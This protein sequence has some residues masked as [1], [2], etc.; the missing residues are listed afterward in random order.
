MAVGV[1]G[2][3]GRSVRRAVTI[4]GIAMVPA[5]CFRTVLEHRFLFR[6]AHPSWRYF[7]PNAFDDV[8]LALCLVL[9]VAV[10][11][12]LFRFG[13]GRS[14][15]WWL[16][17]GLLVVAAAAASLIIDIPEAGEYVY[18]D[19]F[20]SMVS[21]YWLIVFLVGASAWRRWTPSYAPTSW[22]SAPVTGDDEWD[23][24]EWDDEDS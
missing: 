7:L 23:D 6:P 5:W 4:S 20:F 11:A 10:V 18:L 13:L 17:G 2:P 9:A 19:L 24:D 14:G 3:R 12:A 1:E 16:A 8:Y 15:F 22:T 21:G